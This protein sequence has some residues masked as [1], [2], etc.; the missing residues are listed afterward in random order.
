MKRTI[1]IFIAAFLA[2]YCLIMTYYIR[3]LNSKMA[4][5]QK[6]IQA[7]RKVYFYNLDGVLRSVNAIEMKNKFE[8]EIIKLND[9]VFAAEEKIKSIKDA[10]VKD[11]FSD[12]YLKNLKMKRD[13]TVAKYEQNIKNMTN[14][15]NEAL[16]EVAQEHNVSTIFMQNVLAVRTPETYDLTAD[17]IKKIQG[18]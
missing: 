17:I 9:E 15:I 7:N 2:S 6:E 11:D 4:S 13:D 5:Y 18:K 8:A 10:K 3:S 12:V 1:Y 16:A 14:K